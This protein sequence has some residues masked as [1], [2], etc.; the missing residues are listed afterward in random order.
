MRPHWN[1]QRADFLHRQMC[2]RQETEV[3]IGRENLDVAGGKSDDTHEK[4]RHER[5]KKI[6]RFAHLNQQSR[7]E[8]ER[9]HGKELIGQ[10]ETAAREC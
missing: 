9:D 8:T 10:T 2:A 5:D 7:A 4:Q 6:S 1:P 3:W